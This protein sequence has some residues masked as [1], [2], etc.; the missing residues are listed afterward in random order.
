MGCLYA[1][2]PISKCLCPCGG[3]MHGML[4]GK[5]VEK[6]ECSP[7]VRIRCMNGHEGGICRCACRGTNHGLYRTIE[8]FEDVIIK[9][10]D[11]E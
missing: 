9:G 8:G 10:M 6:A 7:A 5:T 4:T 3:N 11:Y 1:E 2:G